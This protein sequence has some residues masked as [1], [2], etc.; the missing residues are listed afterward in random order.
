MGW[1]Q[2]AFKNPVFYPKT[3]AF[4]LGY[5]LSAISGRA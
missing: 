2:I 4:F 5:F 1:G 3:K